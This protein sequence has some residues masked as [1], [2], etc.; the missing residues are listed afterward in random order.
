[1][2]VALASVVAV[3]SFAYFGI[4]YFYTART[5]MNY[6][7]LAALKGSEALSSN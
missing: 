2:I 6:N 3:A 5:S 1:M 4:Y 7:E